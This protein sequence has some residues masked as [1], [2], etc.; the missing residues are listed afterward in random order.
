MNKEMSKRLIKVTKYC[1]GTV[2][3]FT[4]VL[5]GED[6]KW[7]FGYCRHPYGS[8]SGV[9]FLTFLPWQEIFYRVLNYCAEV[10]DVR[11]VAFLD[12]LYSL[13]VPV[14]GTC[15]YVPTSSKPFICPC[16]SDLSL[17]SIPE[18]VRHFFCG[19]VCRLYK[20][21]ILTFIFIP[22]ECQ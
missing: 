11:L 12:R 15:L 20:T 9:L 8:Q 14:A 6:S 13:P 22:E 10:D 1:R 21:I 18:N 4:F 3:L 7:T 17:P 16:P 19:K 5:T 2:E